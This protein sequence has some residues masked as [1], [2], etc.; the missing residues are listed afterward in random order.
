MAYVYISSDEE[1]PGSDNEEETDPSY[2]TEWKDN[3]AT[4]LDAI[5]TAGDFAGSK[6]YSAFVNPDLEVAGS[7]FLCL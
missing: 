2:Y 6:I 4:C 3:L 1:R 7:L 5:E